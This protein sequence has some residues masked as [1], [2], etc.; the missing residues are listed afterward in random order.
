MLST[1]YTNKPRNLV[2]SDKSVDLICHT[3]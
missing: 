3:P 2:S 1:N